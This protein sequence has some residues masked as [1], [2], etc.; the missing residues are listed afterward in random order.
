MEHVRGV[1]SRCTINWLMAYG[2]R[3]WHTRNPTILAKSD[4]ICAQLTFVV[5]FPC[6]I[7][8]IARKF[9]STHFFPIHQS[10]H[11]VHH[12]VRSRPLQTLICQKNK[13][14]HN[15]AKSLETVRTQWP[16]AP[17]SLLL[18]QPYASSLITINAQCM[19]RCGCCGSWPSSFLHLICV[20]PDS[21]LLIC[22]T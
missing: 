4:G 18:G 12:S 13:S 11:S 6:V 19:C 15:P 2:K 3:K 22:Y 16:F 17:F 1:C 21:M 14:A 20:I 7:C 9:F 5:H 8:C 10:I